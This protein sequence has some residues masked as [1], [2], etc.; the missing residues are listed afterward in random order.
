MYKLIEIITKTISKESKKSEKPARVVLNG[1]DDL[2][3]RGREKLKTAMEEAT[4]RTL[5]RVVDVAVTLSTIDI[6]SYQGIGKEVVEKW[7]WEG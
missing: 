1:E 2:T 4:G 3:S 5:Y 7:E 6:A